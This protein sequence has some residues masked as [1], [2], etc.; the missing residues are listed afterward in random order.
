MEKNNKLLWTFGAGLAVG[1]LLG[2]LFAPDKG[3]ETRKKLKISGNKLSENMREKFAR[4]KDALQNL[5]EH[6]AEKID[7]SDDR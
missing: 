1:G 4:G 6:Y 5:R 7:V 3:S 2:V